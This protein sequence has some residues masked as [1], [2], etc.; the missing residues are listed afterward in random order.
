[1]RSIKD[2]PSHER[3]REKL[4]AKGAKALS[5]QEL[6][7]ILLGKGTSRHDVLAIASR[8]S[9]LIDQKG[10]STTTDELLGIEG[11]GHAKACLIAAAFEFVRRRIRPEGVRI[12][13]ASDVVQLIRHYADRRQE[14]FL[15]ISLNGAHEVI[16]T[17]VVTIGLVDQSHVHPREVFAD[18]ITDRASAVILAHNHPSGQLE[19]SREDIHVSE[20]LKV[21]GD[22]LGIKVLD[23]IIF[24]TKGYYSLAEHGQI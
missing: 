19:P 1:M 15:C 4:I 23:H 10:P 20:R 24:T 12:N 17:R 8:L 7:A 16:Q 2:L 6:L 21:A 3:P 18:P 22:V 5:D 14:Y 9:A 11:I 13:C